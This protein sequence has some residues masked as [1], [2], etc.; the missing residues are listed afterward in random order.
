MAKQFIRHLEFYGFPDQ[1]RYSSDVNSSADLSEIIKKNKQQDKEIKNLTNEKA[2]KKDLLELSGTVE[3]LISA[4][5]EFNTM[6]VDELSGITNDINIL[7]NIDDEYGQQ[8]SALTDGLNDA[9]CGIQNLGNRVDDVEEDIEAISGHVLALDDT[10][11]GI[12]EELETKLSKE[13]AEGTYAKKDDVYTKEEVD[14]ILS[15]ELADYATKEWVQEQGYLTE[16]DCDERYAKIETVDA[17]SNRLN[18]A[19]TDLGSKI[20]TVSGDL[21]TYKTVTNAKIGSLETNFAILSGATDRKINAISAAVESY[22]ERISKNASDIDIIEDEL[23]RKANR[24][25]LEALQNTVSNL[26]DRVDTKVSKPEFE[27]YKALV[28]QNLNNL[29][30]KKAD[31][32]EIT[33][34]D[35]EV[36]RLDGKIDQETANRTAADALLQTEIDDINNE[37]DE[38]K[39]Q[40]VDYG[41]RIVALETGLTDEIAAREQ[42]KVDLIGQESDAIDADT[43]W[44]AKNFAKNQKRQA[45]DTANEYTDQEVAALRTWTEN[46][47]NEV[48]Q[49]LTGKAST[50]FVIDNRNELKREL[51]EEFATAIQ[52]E[53]DRASL[54]EVNLWNAVS[55]NTS[56]IADNKAEIDHNANRIGT[57]TAWD[58]EDPADY[59]DSGNG[60]LDVLHREF[61]RYASSAGSIRDVRIEDGNLIIT[62]ITPTGD[63]E[64]ST[65]ITD[66]FD[67]N[68]YYDK[69][70]TDE[71]LAAKADATALTEAIDGI[72]DGAPES[73]NTLNKIADYITAN[74][75]NIVE[76]NDKINAN[77]ADIAANTDNIAQ[78]TQD[79]ATNANNI[80]Q[81]TADIDAAEAAIEQNTADIAANTENIAQNTADIAENSADI[82]TNTANI[83][84]NTQDI[85]KNTADIEAAETAIENINTELDTKADAADVPTTQQFEEQLATKANKAEVAVAL[86]SKANQSEVNA[87]LATKVDSTTF[88]NAFNT[89]DNEKADAEDME[90]Q[91]REK[92]SLA[93]YQAKVNDLQAQIDALRSIIIGG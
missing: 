56:A 17:L 42:Q 51:E 35:G 34:L 74:T 73:Y 25:D 40:G 33:R 38:I 22:D 19:V 77:T 24:V 15:E 41:E 75:Q 57:I 79:I 60:I 70:Q 2:D 7:K 80:A 32:T 50:G 67:A 44:G 29:D 39:E 43:I 90:A 89:L 92:V 65:P 46:E 23:V 55:A 11:E 45:I 59:D 61:H 58:G 8:L 12:Q 31:K 64:V 76:I 82:A 10:V 48:E 69:T 88:D 20:Y 27:T 54:E 91:L 81:N 14:E 78:N 68:A 21:E 47:F 86:A 1:N 26:S 9:I 49:E 6:V 4:Q 63:Q 52:E 72:V 85:A 5:T 3:T 93:V 62:Y 28:S 84:Q 16:A 87:A 53:A 83:A 37:I 71:L 30:N 36:E 18:D 66:I 13:E